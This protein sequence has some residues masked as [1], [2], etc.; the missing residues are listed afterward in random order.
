MSGQKLSHFKKGKSC[1]HPLHGFSKFKLQFQSVTCKHKPYSA[2]TRNTVPGLLR[3]NKS[4]ICNE[5]V[6]M[7]HTG[8][9]TV[10]EPTTTHCLFL[11]CIPPSLFQRTRR[12]ET[13]T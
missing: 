5:H 13:E 4:K 9:L 7:L 8:K 11:N 2:L 10:C 12:I 1:T 6:Y 3:Y